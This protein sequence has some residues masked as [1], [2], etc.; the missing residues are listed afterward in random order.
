[1]KNKHILCLAIAST[2]LS[3]CTTFNH[4]NNYF[5]EGSFYC[6]SPESDVG[7]TLIV[8]RIDKETFDSRNGTN[9]VFDDVIFEYFALEL[10]IT[11]S[12]ETVIVYNF[13]GLTPISKSKDWPVSYMDNNKALISPHVTSSNINKS[14]PVYS[15]ELHRNQIEGYDFGCSLFFNG[16]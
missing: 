1:M 10:S 6:V 3:A 7:C 4:R 12:E 9:V 15:I 2:V 14:R 13:V 5:I 11:L 8:T 16:E